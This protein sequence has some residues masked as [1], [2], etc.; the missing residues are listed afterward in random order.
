[1]VAGGLALMKQLF[2]DQ[3]S[4]AELV[5]R[6]LDTADNTGIYSDRD[7]YGRGNGSLRRDVACG[8]S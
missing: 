7:T 4:S 8:S 2:R 6:L 1:M 5:G 3:I